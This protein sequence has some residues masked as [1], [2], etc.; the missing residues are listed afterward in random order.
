MRFLFKYIVVHVVTLNIAFG[1]CYCR[2]V[3]TKKQ[4]GGTAPFLYKVN[5]FYLY[6]S[7]GKPGRALKIFVKDYN[8]PISIKVVWNSITETTKFNQN[9]KLN[10]LLLPTGA[11]V[12]SATN[13]NITVTAGDKELFATIPVPVK[14]QWT[15]YVYPHSHLDIG[16]TGLPADVLKLQTRN[17][18]VGIDIA[19]KTQNYPEGSRFVW[20]TEATWVVEQYLQQASPAQKQKFIEAVKKGWIQ[21]DGGHSNSNTSTF[22]DEEMIHFFN[23]ASSIQKVTGVP[24]K[25]MVQMDVPGAAWGLVT[26]A[27]QFGINRFISFPNYYDLRKFWENKP[28]Y[29]LGPDGKTK[30]LFLQGCPYGI[31]YTIKGSKYG[32]AKIQ[33]YTNEYDRVSTSTPSEN[34]LNP[35]IFEETAR[36]EEKGSPYDL[37]AITWSMAD[38]CVIDADLPEAVKEWNKKYAYPKLII[39][40]A[41]DILDA[42]EKKYG[43]VIP[44]YSGD[45]T[46]FWTNGLGSDAKS[47]GEGREGKELLV[48]AEI[49]SSM[50]DQNNNQTKITADAWVDQLLSAEHTWGAQDSKSV[51]A[52]QVEKIKSG[53]FINSKRKSE[54]LLA[55]T[56]ASFKD[57]TVSTF[58]IVN[59]LSWERNGIVTL[60]KSQSRF[61]DGIVDEK[62]N[63]VL[64]QRLST[65]ELIFRA[66]QIPALGSKLYKV[67][68]NKPK[69]STELKATT[70][71]LSNARLSLQVS[72][73]TGNITSV[74]NFKNG[75]E[76]V[77]ASS[78]LN[79]YQYVTGV[80]NGKDHPANPTTTSDVSVRVKENGPLLVSL[81]VTAKAQGV[82]QLSREIKLYE[83]SSAVELTNTFDKISTRQKE[84]IHFGFGFALPNATG[85]I[86]MPWSI[87]SPNSDILESGNKNWFAFQ[88]W[89]DISNK[90]YGVTW[91][92]IQSPL[93]EWGS[94]SGNI[95]DGGRQPW[96]WLKDVPKSSLIYSW[97]VNNHWDTNFPL[98][99]G[100]LMKQCYAF[101]IHD[102]YDVVAANRFGMETQRP[103]IAVQTKNNLISKSL[104]IINNDRLVISM[105]KKSR[106]DKLSMT[107]FGK[108][109]MT[110]DNK[111]ILLRVRSISDK[112]EVL[113]LDWPSAKPKEITECNA[114]EENG[115]SFKN[116]TEIQPYGMI[117]LRLV[118]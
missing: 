76:Y 20:N 25:T 64:S 42:Y 50:F 24:I 54:E 58:S 16:Y 92:A 10:D 95:L 48:Q 52:R 9:D 14:K 67:V 105:I 36:F 13:V 11:G 73:Q 110:R 75:Y 81:L 100:G 47:V 102:A 71:V 41:K 68:A 97:P 117:N 38:N 93:I 17:I 88:R 60:T 39:G 22:S 3:S 33:K 61:G 77:D 62:N 83:G 114:D 45:F 113:K 46:E 4:D 43:A 89:V 27:A 35:F 53:Y 79:S 74:K 111:V 37:F 21:I 19:E 6:R 65:G 55:E 51:L 96:L 44:T 90:Q 23:N 86:D 34:F 12:D 28:F 107:R 30:M 63:P 7:D 72:P 57:T 91:S 115:K 15:V 78:G 26:A 87:V 49:L 112:K 106:F 98:E 108:L 94:L 118:F 99:Q 66:E 59:T 69:L 84:G 18:D 80:Y 8:G 32:L 31:G 109:S 56:V 116:S 29:W 5:P 101:N 1:I 2:P 40:G 103:L 70:T 104:V 82:N 85:R